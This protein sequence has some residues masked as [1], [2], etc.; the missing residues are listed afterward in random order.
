MNTWNTHCWDVRVVKN[1]LQAEFLLSHETFDGVAFIESRFPYLVE[2]NRTWESTFQDY[3]TPAK[4]FY[5][6]REKHDK[7]P[8]FCSNLYQLRIIKKFDNGD[9]NIPVIALCWRNMLIDNKV[10][11]LTLELSLNYHLLISQISQDLLS[12][13]QNFGKRLTPGPFTF[14]SDTS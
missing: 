7:V 10:C 3:D 1:N 13:N 5:Q 9:G 11:A 4:T 2:T 8:Q 6:P 12:N 14:N